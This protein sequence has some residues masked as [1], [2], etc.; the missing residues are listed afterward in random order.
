MRRTAGG[1]AGCSSVPHTHGTSGRACSPQRLP[2]PS[3]S[4]S[5]LPLPK[6]RFHFL[7]FNQRQLSSAGGA[8]RPLQ[9]TCRPYIHTHTNNTALAGCTYAG[10]AQHINLALAHPRSVFYSRTAAHR[11]SVSS[12]VLVNRPRQS[13]HRLNSSARSQHTQYTRNH[14][15]KVRAACMPACPPANTD[16]SIRSPR[17]P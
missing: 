4:S 6:L 14:N 5:L 9:Q 16:C 13:V 12:I 10:C 17:I 15:R 2:P 3:T 7:G 8:R 11:Q 1:V